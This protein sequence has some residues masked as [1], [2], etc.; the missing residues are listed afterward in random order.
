MIVNHI[1][2]DV[3]C[4][5]SQLIHFSNKYLEFIQFKGGKHIF[6]VKV[7]Y[8]DVVWVSKDFR[9]YLIYFIKHVLINIH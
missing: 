2:K 1:R 5:N 8:K 9:T 7:Q 4:I 6:D 3:P